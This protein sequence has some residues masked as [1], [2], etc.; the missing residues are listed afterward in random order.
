MRKTARHER[1][2]RPADR[3]KIRDRPGRECCGNMY[4]EAVAARLGI[5]C[6]PGCGGSGLP[7]VT[8]RSP[9]RLMHAPD[10]DGE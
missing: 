7:R 3:V 4:V 2:S 8:A 9:S 10:R 6:R 5:T 1:D